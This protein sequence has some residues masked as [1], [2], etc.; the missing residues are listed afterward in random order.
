MRDSKQDQ[1]IEL[2]KEKPIKLKE[3][4]R[5]SNYHYTT[6]SKF[7]IQDYVHRDEFNVFNKVVKQIYFKTDRRY[8]Y[9]EISNISDLWDKQIQSRPF[10]IR[11]L[12]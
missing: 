11:E 5:N 10:D 7:P 1:T 3:S 6:F 8:W 4:V 9:D 2:V 12:K